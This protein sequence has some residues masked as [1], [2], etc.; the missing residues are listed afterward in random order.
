VKKSEVEHVIRAAKKITGES[1]FVVIDSQAL[2]GAFPNLVDKLVTSHECDIYI[3]N[4]PEKTELLNSIGMLTPFAQTYGYYADPVDPDTAK[5]PKSWPRR[6]IAISTRNTDGAIYYCPAPEDLVFS[7]LAAGREKDIR[8]VQALLARN[9]IKLA[10]V[11]RS[12]AAIE[13]PLFQKLMQDRLSIVAS[14]IP[15][16]AAQKRAATSTLQAFDG[17]LSVDSP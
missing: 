15:D 2:H 7:K 8:F 1:E 10:S 17:P 14:A 11:K 13:D 9:L 3:P 6:K 4:A 12:I 5:L 16:K